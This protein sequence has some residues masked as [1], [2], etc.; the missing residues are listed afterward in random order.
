MSTE[1]RIYFSEVTKLLLLVCPAASVEAER[2]FSALRRLK[3]WLRSSM[4]QERLNDA[5]MCNI[6]Q[7][8]L[9]DVDVRQLLKEFV[10]RNSV[11]VKLFG[12]FI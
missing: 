2:S 1:T 9:D 3:T 8:L 5:A 4:S 6:H 11:R 12:N 7:N 10:A